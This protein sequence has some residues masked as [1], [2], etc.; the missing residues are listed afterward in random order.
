MRPNIV[1]HIA[2]TTKLVILWKGNPSIPPFQLRARTQI[3]FLQKINF[4]FP[5][6][7]SHVY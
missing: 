5:I 4:E 2:L 1:R 7:N 3:P 6:S